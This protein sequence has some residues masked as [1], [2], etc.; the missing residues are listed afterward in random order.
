MKN[1]SPVLVKQETKQ[2]DTAIAQ[3]HPSS[4][5]ETLR[6]EMNR[7]F[8][9]FGL[10]APLWRQTGWPMPQQAL[11]FETKIEVKDREKDFVITAEVPGVELQ[12]L[13]LAATPHYISL[14]GEKKAQ[15]SETDQGYY[16]MEREYGFF[17]RVIHMPCEIDRDH[18]DAEFANGILT[19]V[20][21]KT[22]AA[23]VDEKK[24][25]VKKG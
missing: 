6:N 8:D 24:I 14:S 4:M 25:T 7:L 2:N 15:K 11:G 23:L 21:P 12:D 13:T 10:G 1:A 17:R 20:I 22:K 5:F 18:I 3:R 9:D 16:N 19:L